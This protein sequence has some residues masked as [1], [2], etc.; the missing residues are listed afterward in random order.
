MKKAKLIKSIGVLFVF[1]ATL[2]LSAQCD[3]RYQ[4]EL[5]EEVSVTTV[6]YSSVHNLKVDIYQA[7]GDTVTNRPLLILAHGGVFIAGERTNPTMV[8]LG[9]TFAKRG[10]VVASISYRL[11]SVI[12]LISSQS[13]T[14]G[15]VRALSDGRAAVRYFRKTVAE[16]GN[17]YAIDENQIYFGGNSAGGVIAAHAAFLQ[18]DEIIEPD[19]IE[20]FN[21]VGGIEGDSGNDGYSSEVKGAISLAGALAEVNFITLEENDKLLISCHGEDDFTV[22]YSCGQPL[23]SVSF[24]SI[25]PE[26]CGGGAMSEHTEAIGFTNHHYL[27]FENQGHVPWDIYP[28]IE[29]E[30]I[31]FVSTNL[32]NSLDCESLHTALDETT[33]LKAFPNPTSSSIR[34][35]IENQKNKVIL[36]N[37][38]GTEVMRQENTNE[39]NVEHLPKGFYTVQLI[40]DKQKSTFTKVVKL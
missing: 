37:T 25:L 29:A 38:N 1:F 24:I 36:Y 14:N 16:E 31:A 5:F 34:F 28:S 32:Y 30:M 13:A 15:V 23:L 11:M 33:K 8:T 27:N 12:D 4:E 10:Y 6:K 9:N 26:L 3:G 35:S 20:A 22:P 40:D 21:A 18:E 2:S 7:L 39:I 19:L 17:P